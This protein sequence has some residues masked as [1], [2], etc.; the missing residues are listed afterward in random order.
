M[1]VV[2]QLMT[3]YAEKAV[4]YLPKLISTDIILVIGKSK[5]K[6]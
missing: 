2:N 5:N 1:G 3:Q 4:S 6:Q